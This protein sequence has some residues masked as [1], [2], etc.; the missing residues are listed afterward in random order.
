MEPEDSLPHSQVPT[1][2]LSRASSI[3]FLTPHPTSGRSILILFS[4]LCLGLPSGLFLSGYPTNN[5][6]TPFLSPRLATCPAH[7]ILLDFIT[8]TLLGEE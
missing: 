7:L 3:Q 8:R 5:L 4:Y 6:Y 2:C 1:T